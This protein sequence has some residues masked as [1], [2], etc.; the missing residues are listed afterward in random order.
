MKKRRN[1]FTAVSKRSDTE[2]QNFPIIRTEFQAFQEMVCMLYVN[3]ICQLA[4]SLQ[5]I[6]KQTFMTHEV[7]AYFNSK[8]INF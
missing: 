7:G 1:S 8:F 2:R 4:L 3:S 6:R 5:T